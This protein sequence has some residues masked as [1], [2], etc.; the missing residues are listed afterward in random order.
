MSSVRTAF[1][2]RLSMQRALGSI[3]AGVL[4]FLTET[5]SQ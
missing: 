1:A 5:K 3:L 2:G 4:P